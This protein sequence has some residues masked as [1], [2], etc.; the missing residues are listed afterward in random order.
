MQL[1]R[2]R[3]VQSVTSLSRMT[4]YR[5]ERAG[6]FPRRRQLGSN[7]VGW[8]DDE[9]HEWLRSRPAVVLPEGPTDAASNR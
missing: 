5:L 2:I 4:I 7:S 9:I 1:L 8:L 6:L 3:Q